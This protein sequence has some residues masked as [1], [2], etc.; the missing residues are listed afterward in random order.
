VAQKCRTRGDS[1]L[2]PKSLVAV[3]K[4]GSY[5]DHAQSIQAE[6]E[7]K[8]NEWKQTKREKKMS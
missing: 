1:G 4:E 8:Q 3:K 6:P 7:M 5:I 2:F